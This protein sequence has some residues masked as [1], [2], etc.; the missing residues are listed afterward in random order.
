MESLV[1][2]APDSKFSY[3]Y[4]S[5]V[6]NVLAFLW[7]DLEEKKKSGQLNT[8]VQANNIFVLFHPTFWNVDDAL[9]FIDIVWK[10]IFKY[11]P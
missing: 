4:D 10:E 11:V 9:A 1:W 5:V 7:N 8:Y 2:N 6:Q 3:G